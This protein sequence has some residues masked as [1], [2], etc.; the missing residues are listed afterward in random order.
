MIESVATVPTDRPE[1]YLKQL[2]S[3]LGT[4]ID[5][6][7]SEDGHSGTL[8]FSAGSCALT[9]EP[10]KLHMTA[11]AQDPE[12]LAAVEDV[13][14]RHLVRFGEKEALAVEWSGAVGS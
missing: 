10:G 11:R 6:E 12:R 7:K 3:H 2:I 8:I 13:V 14:A 9:A 5:A 1:R 4:Q